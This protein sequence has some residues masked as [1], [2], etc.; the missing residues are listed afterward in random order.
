M[1]VNKKGK[2]KII[3]DKKVYWWF[4]DDTIWDEPYVRIIADDHSF[5]AE[6]NLYCP[7]LRIMKDNSK[8]RRSISIPCELSHRYLSFTPQYISELIRIGSC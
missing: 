5:E 3:V 2:R 7:V 4:A 6:C 1:G 8:G